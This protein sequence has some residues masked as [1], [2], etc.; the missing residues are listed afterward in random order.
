MKING[1]FLAIA[2]LLFVG[3]MSYF[4]VNINTPYLT[5]LYFFRIVLIIIFTGFSFRDK[6]KIKGEKLK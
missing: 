2:I 1:Y 5:F 6:Q 3:H 4:D